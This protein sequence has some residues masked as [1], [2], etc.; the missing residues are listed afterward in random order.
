V[1]D[2]RP[3]LLLVSG[4]A[5]LLLL[6]AC[7]NV[8][9]LLL[10]RWAE[11]R[12][13]IAI[14]LAIGANRLRVVRQFVT[15][16][17]ALAAAGSAAGLGVALA[18]LKAITAART[19]GIAR[20]DEVR[21]D[22]GV[23]AVLAC[24]TLATAI[25]FGLFPALRSADAPER[26][27]SRGAGG[28]ERGR[29]AGSLIAAEIGLSLV[30]LCAT[31]LLA[32]S[33]WRLLRVDPGFVPSHVLTA[34]LDAPEGPG[35][36]NREAA[37]FEAVLREARRIPGVVGASAVN[38]LPLG[39]ANRQD[40]IVVEGKPEPAP[41]DIPTTDVAI[42]ERHYFGAMRIPLL[43]GRGFLASDDA[44]KPR[45]A[46]VSAAAARRFWPGEDP[47]GR[48]FTNARPKPGRPWF[49]V[50]G[51]VGDVRLAIDASPA[52]EIY[53]PISQR[54]MGS[55]TL[56]AR[57]SGRPELAAAPLAAAVRRVD[58][59]QPLYRVVPLE[60]VAAVA[61]ADR[62]FLLILLGAFA[63]AGLVLSVAGLSG[64]V[65]RI[66]AGRTREIGIRMA[67]GATGRNVVTG[68]LRRIAPPVAAGIVGGSVAAVAAGRAL[69]SVLYGVAAGDPA[70]YLA[71]SV[72]LAAVAAAAAWLPARRAARIDPMRALREE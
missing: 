52:S 7:A 72:L 46:I 25:L 20:L 17:L 68:V 58:P 8:S 49:T 3:A 71:V 55:L 18:L 36:E 54:A 69:R 59:G 37:F 50:V 62:R 28:P 14:R 63:A 64:V 47:L 39:A 42:V 29:F 2:V 57:T 40:G 51:V 19:I 41:E 43:R 4:G 6:I 32:R 33:F 45:V 5:G 9:N 22:G 65:A 15:E 27:A 38:P 48:R 12:R 67:L 13:E 34:R 66:V 1:G 56:V 60:A 35:T 16:G 70:T 11:R 30:L 21:I 23:L 31:G 44:D 61:L 24:T 26:L 10:A 53:Y